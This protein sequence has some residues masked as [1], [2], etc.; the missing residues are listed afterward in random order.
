MR[1]S[2]YAAGCEKAAS[3]RPALIASVVQRVRF[4]ADHFHSRPVIHFPDPVLQRNQLVAH[5]D[6]CHLLDI[7]LAA[8]VFRLTAHELKWDAVGIEH[9][10]CAHLFNIKKVVFSSDLAQRHDFN[11]VG[12]SVRCVEKQVLKIAEPFRAA[13]RIAHRL[14]VGAAL[15]RVGH[16]HDIPRVRP[17]LV[18][19]AAKQRRGFVKPGRVKRAEIFRHPVKLLVDIRL[20]QVKHRARFKLLRLRKARHPPVNI[21]LHAAPRVFGR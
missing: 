6:L 2:A 16:V 13:H 12:L 10:G 19:L 18:I 20:Q 21:L 15:R 7:A 14:N 4:K 8:D 9:V 11:P 17:V 3:R 5:K 1:L